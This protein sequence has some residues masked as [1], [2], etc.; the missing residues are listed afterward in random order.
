M[1]MDWQSD[2][3]MIIKRPLRRGAGYFLSGV[4]GGVPQ[5]WGI[6][7]LIKIISAVSIRTGDLY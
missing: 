4:S 1:L 5:D 3:V 2:G 6:R 7:G